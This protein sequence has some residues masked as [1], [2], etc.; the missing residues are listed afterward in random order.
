M[1][2]LIVHTIA[3]QLLVKSMKETKSIKKT[4]IPGTQSSVRLTPKSTRTTPVRNRKVRS[5]QLN[6]LQRKARHAQNLY[7]AIKRNEEEMRHKNNEY[8]RSK[9]ELACLLEGLGLK[10]IK[11]DNSNLI[12]Q[13]KERPKYQFDADIIRLEHELE[14][15]K[16]IAIDTGKAT[17]DITVYISPYISK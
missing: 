15:E 7:M 4:L 10:E 5:V 14:A 1:G 13:L 2:H 17:K 8:K 6:S 9:D 16:Q 12:F 11:C 3:F